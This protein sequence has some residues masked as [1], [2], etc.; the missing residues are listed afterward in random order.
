MNKGDIVYYQHNPNR[1][2][3]GVVVKPHPRAPRRYVH[4]YTPDGFRTWTENF[5]CPVDKLTVIEEA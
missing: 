5:A 1:G 2:Y 3:Y 4:L